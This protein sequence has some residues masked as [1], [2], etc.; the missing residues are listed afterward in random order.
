MSQ[1][2][3]ILLVLV[4]VGTMTACSESS[5]AQ[6][7]NG[8]FGG[9]NSVVADSAVINLLGDEMCQVLFSPS[10]VTCYQMAPTFGGE[11]SDKDYF[12]K[13]ERTKIGKLETYHQVPL[14]L[15]LAD[16]SNYNLDTSEEPKC[17]FAPY[18]AFEF[19]GANK[20]VVTV[21]IS[22]NCEKWA[23][24]QDGKV[25]AYKYSCQPSLVRFCNYLLPEDKYLGALK[26][27]F[28]NS[29]AIPTQGAFHAFIVADINDNNIGSASLKDSYNIEMEMQAVAKAL[30]YS[31]EKHALQGDNFFA[32][33][34]EQ[35]LKQ[36]KCGANDVVFFYFSGYGGREATDKSAF[37]RMA[38]GTSS[39]DT[40]P[41]DLVERLITSKNPRLTVVMADCGQG[42]FGASN[43][44]G[45][46]KDTPLPEGDDRLNQNDLVNRYKALFMEASG[47][48]TVC[49]AS[50]GGTAMSTPEGGVFTQLFLMDLNSGSTNDWKSLLERVKQQSARFGQMPCYEIR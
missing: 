14:Q 44:Q 50:Q 36:L 37:P 48:V 8:S 13:A 22:F 1:N 42:V 33:K 3:W 19:T 23:F 45:T 49:A 4:M 6:K 39:K 43:N 11:G 15:F 26:G 41:L 32:A 12:L 25:V 28:E 46:S 40:M 35:E 10:K 18:L 17:F 2:K 24:E 5:V 16:I 31:F 21:Y 27:T 7:S 30:N 9:K 38:F 29:A 47:S 20:K 34:V